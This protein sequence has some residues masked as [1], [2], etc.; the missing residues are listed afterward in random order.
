MSYQN[1]K[2]IT[3]N[4]ILIKIKLLKYRDSF[5]QYFC[6]YKRKNLPWH[7]TL[8]DFKSFQDLKMFRHPFKLHVVKRREEI[9]V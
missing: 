5:V 1:G 4:Y 3:I 2:V 7:L 8:H 9:F 6:H